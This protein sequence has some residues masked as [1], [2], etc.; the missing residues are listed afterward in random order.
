MSRQMDLLCGL[1]EGTRGEGGGDQRAAR[2]LKVAKLVDNDGVPC[3]FGR[4][5]EG[6]TSQ[7][8]N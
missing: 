6:P 5:F 8:S 4:L 2:D 7:H 1:M 3:D